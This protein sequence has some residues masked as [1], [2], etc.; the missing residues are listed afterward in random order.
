L[1]LEF[2]KKGSCQLVFKNE[3]DTEHVYK[4]PF[5]R[6]SFSG[7]K[8]CLDA[9]GESKKS[10]FWRFKKDRL[11]K[12]RF[13]QSF[14]IL[15][16]LSNQGSDDERYF[17]PIDLLDEENVLLNFEGSCLSYSGPLIKQ[18]K[19]FF[20]NNETSLD[21]FNW[22]HVAETH[23]NLWKKGVGLTAP[24]EAWGPKNWGMTRTKK[25][26]LVD[27]SH[28]SEDVYEI[29]QYLTDE[30]KLRRMN[31]LMDFK[32]IHNPQNVRAYFDF[33]SKYLNED[34]LRKLWKTD[35]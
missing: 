7:N 15:S 23:M 35:S 25:V 1:K 19:V 28:L 33:L 13:S 29:A 32:K 3:G 9:I 10:F 34:N 24:A 31:R 11:N 17:A 20:F 22:E 12:K 30:I 2:Y 4:I 5:I 18:Q 6:K 21:S 27:T 16:R 14:H 8:N 26:R